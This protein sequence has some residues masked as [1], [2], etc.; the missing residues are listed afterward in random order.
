MTM[1]CTKRSRWQS[2]AA[3]TVAVGI[4]VW[5]YDNNIIIM[6]ADGSQNDSAIKALI[7]NQGIVTLHDFIAG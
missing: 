2:L 3:A 1:S 4:V 6:Q 5:R 7:L